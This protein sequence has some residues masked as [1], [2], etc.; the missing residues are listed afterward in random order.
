MRDTV[1][2]TRCGII[3]EKVGARGEKEQSVY[4]RLNM[5]TELAYRL[6]WYIV[7]QG[8][9]HPETASPGNTWTANVNGE[10]QLGPE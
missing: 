4:S 2:R 6:F 1:Q 5:V 10:L 3:G 8:H 7:F 9:E